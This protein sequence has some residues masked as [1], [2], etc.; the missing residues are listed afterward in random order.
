MPKLMFESENSSLNAKLVPLTKWL[1]CEPFF[2]IG[3]NT[4]LAQFGVIRP[5]FRLPYVPL[6]MGERIEFVKI[7]EEIGRE[8]FVDERDVRVLDDE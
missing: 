4:A 8:N 3:L 2:V 7:V 1:F 6:S 5:V